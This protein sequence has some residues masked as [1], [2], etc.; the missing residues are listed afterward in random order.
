MA[1][2]TREDATRNC[3]NIINV[4]ICGLQYLVGVQE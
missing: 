4:V 2:G 1:E 3:A